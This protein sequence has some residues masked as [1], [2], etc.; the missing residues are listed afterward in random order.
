MGLG[1]DSWKRPPCVR[2]LALA[3]WFGMLTA[4]VL[5]F[6]L[7]L[8]VPAAEMARAA[9]EPPAEQHPAASRTQADSPRHR[10]TEAAEA[11][12]EPLPAAVTTSHTVE[13][14]PHSLHFKAMVGP[15]RLSDAQSAAPLADIATAAFLLEG[16]DPAKRPVTFALNGGP[17]A[18]SAWL[19]LGGLGPWRLP[20]EHANL[21]PSASPV[22]IANSDT[23]L[24]FTDLVFIDPP[25]TGYSRILT[26]E[27]GA[28]R[29]LFSVNGDIEALAVAIRKWLADNKRLESPKFLTGESYGGFRAPRLAR[30][31][32]ETEGIGIA[33]LLL[34]SPV[35]D[36]SWWSEGVANPLVCA[37]RLPSQAAAARGLTGPDARASLADVEAYAAGAYITDLL[38]GERD[39]QALARISENVAHFTG[40]DPAL[41]RKLGGR[42]DPA[43]FAR[44]KNRASAKVTSLYDALISGY[45]P[46]PHAAASDYS[47]PVIDA[48]KVPL[49]SAM[50]EITANRLGW[51]VDGR[52]EILSET[53]NHAWDW[54]SG[55][56][57][58]ESL[59]DLK[60]IMALDPA[61]RV[62]VAHGVTD[63]VT[64][65]F[66]SNIIIDQIAP[67]G[68]EDRLRLKVYG[69]GHMLY[70]N[71]TTRAELRE[72]ARRL[73][74][75]H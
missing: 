61:L 26:K 13:V 73:I 38:R 54:G 21:P 43:T 24:D 57:H 75:G 39:A 18:A 47:D 36:F 40:L 48:V 34:I 55:R 37:A 74:E 22:T 49:A 27:D 70:F 42:I 52:Y 6:L 31:L 45:D 69:G 63:Q 7:L 15:I 72:D 56:D 35:L 46:S 12:P 1:K 23:W 62:L 17:G 51:F 30:R 67:M 59:S 8:P 5:L 3:V 2:A 65:Y 4:S 64:P 53:V 68:R 20:L 10:A 66:A 28:R 41:V 19:N 25:G 60:R 50:A 71:D 33:G 29:H 14:P 11:A 32:G 16:A 44:E 9:A 58:L